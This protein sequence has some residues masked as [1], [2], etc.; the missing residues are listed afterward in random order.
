MKSTN[1]AG[2]EVRIRPCVLSS[3]G[4]QHFHCNTLY[5]EYEKTE[6]RSP[7]KKSTNTPG[8]E[9]RIRAFVFPSPSGRH[10]VLSVTL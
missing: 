3:L 4:G 1:T 8:L 2:V 6:S 7:N 10:F 5:T 9:V